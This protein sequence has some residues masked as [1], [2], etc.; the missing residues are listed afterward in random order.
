MKID[1]LQAGSIYQSFAEKTASAPSAG[2]SAADGTGEGSTADR[3]EISAR[4]SDMQ[5]ARRLASSARTA[6]TPGERQARIE[7][8]RSQITSG[9]YQVPAEAVARSILLGANFDTRA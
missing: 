5:Q 9:Q 6:E 8:I 7:E 3:V 4:A 1:G 2:V